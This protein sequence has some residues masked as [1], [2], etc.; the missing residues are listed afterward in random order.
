[1]VFV[2][3][4]LLALPIEVGRAFAQFLGVIRANIVCRA[5]LLGG[6]LGQTSFHLNATRIRI[7]C[8]E[9]T[10]VLATGAASVRLR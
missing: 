5:D 3:G 6:T 1:M 7:G 10:Q 4:T 8:V 2:V 9:Q